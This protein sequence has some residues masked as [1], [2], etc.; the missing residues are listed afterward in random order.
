MND[1]LNEIKQLIIN[2]QKDLAK[3][4]SL[5]DTNIANLN[6]MSDD[7]LN[8]LSNLEMRYNILE[9]QVQLIQKV[10]I[11]NSSSNNQ[12]NDIISINSDIESNDNFKLVGQNEYPVKSKEDKKSQYDDDDD[13][14]P[15]G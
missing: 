1:T 3:Y 4:N 12:S 2:L 15:V 7:I 14:R 10:L 6:H 11:N 9:S 13:F 8:R 5:S